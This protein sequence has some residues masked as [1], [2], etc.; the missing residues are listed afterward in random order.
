VR[1]GRLTGISDD[2]GKLREASRAYMP[3]GKRVVIVGGG[4]VGAELAE[5]LCERGRQVVVLEESATLAAEMAHPRRW[6]ALHELREHG[7][8]M[9]VRARV[10]EIGEMTVRFELGPAKEGA[11]TKRDEAAADTVILA[12][13][14]EANPAPAR[15]LR[16]AGV[17][18]IEIGD[19]TGVGYIEGAVHSGFEAGCEI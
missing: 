19:A 10:L 17:P 16:E 3:V 15:L 12:A 5:F 2:P 4:L 9:H 11:E 6:R 7:V 13:G 14:L 18:V 1:A 8:R